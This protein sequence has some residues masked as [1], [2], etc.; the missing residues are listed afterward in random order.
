MN[1]FI[2]HVIGNDEQTAFEY[3]G[4]AAATYTIGEAL[5][6]NANG[7]LALASGTTKP[8]YFAY[9]NTTITAAGD[10][11]CVTRVRDDIIY[12]THNSAAFTSIKLGNKV[13]IASD[14]LRVTATTTDGVVTVVGIEDTGVGSKIRVKF[15]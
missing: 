1:G 11:L 3:K 8:E 7:Y 14:G 5:A 6:Y 13:T 10:P 12:E 9:K 4:A 2:P 15:E